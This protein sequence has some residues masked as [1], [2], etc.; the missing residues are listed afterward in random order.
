MKR[1]LLGALLVGHCA[2][3]VADGVARLNAFLESTRSFR[4]TF[5]QTV[6][7]KSGKKPQAS[8]GELALSR[9][10]KFRWQIDKPYQQLLVGDGSRVWLYDPDLRQA[11]VKKM[12]ETLGGTPAAILAGEPG[13]ASAITATF[14][15]SD[16]GER[17]GQVWVDA[18][19]RAADASFERVRFGFAGDQLRTMEMHDNFGQAT[20]IEFVASERNPV[21]AAT[22]FRFAPPPG[23]D[24][25]GE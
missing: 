17:D 10:G 4:A 15:V 16:A 20:V 7:F 6:Y 5:V 18:T 24:V 13:K 14:V 21:L 11:T 23:V 19:P 22:L 2:F 1:L 9:P 25:I 8:S 3:A 12:A